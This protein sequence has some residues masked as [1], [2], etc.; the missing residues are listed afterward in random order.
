MASYSDATTQPT[1]SSDELVTQ[2][3]TAVKQGQPNRARQ[4]LQEAVRRDPQNYRAWLWLASI[5]PT[6]QASLDY[7]VRA[8][9]LQPDEPAVQEARVWAEERI[10]APS[11]ANAPQES[12]PESG[13]RSV[14]WKGSLA[15]I[16]ALLFGLAALFVWS[17]L[18]AET[19]AG[20]TA[21]SLPNPP[22]AAV[23]GNDDNFTAVSPPADDTPSP[24][25]PAKSIGS[26]AGD[27][28]PTWTATP[29]PSPTPTPAPT[30]VPT[31]VSP[32]YQDAQRPFGAAPDERWIDVNLS[33]Q[34]L[35]AYE[36]DTPVFETSISGGLPGF[37]TVTGQ[38]RIWLRYESQTMDGRLLGYDYYL[39]NVPYVMYFYQDYALHGAYW[40][41]S[42]GQPMS[43]GCVNI[44]PD[45][46][47]W[48]FNWASLGTL[49]NVHY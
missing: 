24:Q 8:E 22:I 41:N 9:M 28:R 29:I 37:E 12:P 30:Y 20:T 26:K 46:A 42:F 5:A 34:Y 6:P 43:H 40:H 36:G 32:G 25:I 11:P 35:T 19:D 45:K 1:V 38:F 27:P 17:N 14:I 7:V 13:S 15:L 21:V 18:R 39:E 48:L 23:A 47:G 10:A 3:A 31:F 49:V 16:V 44:A 2:A 33:S 4:L